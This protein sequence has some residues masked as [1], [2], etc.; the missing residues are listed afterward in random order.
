[1]L[2]FNYPATFNFTQLNFNDGFRVISNGGSLSAIN[3]GDINGDGY[4]DF[5]IS[6]CIILGSK[7]LY[8]SKGII[9]SGVANVNVP[10]VCFNGGAW[11]DITGDF[12][13]DGIDD[14]I[15]QTNYSPIILYGSTEGLPASFNSTWINGKN[16]IIINTPLLTS[17]GQLNGIGDINGDK[18]ADI[19]MSLQSDSNGNAY[20]VILGSKNFPAG[21]S[22]SDL[23]GSNGFQVITKQISLSALPVRDINH[24]G[25]GDVLFYYNEGHQGG[26]GIYYNVILL[27]SKLFSSPLNIDNL[28]AGE[29]VVINLN[30]P[31]AFHD[32]DIYYG[33]DDHTF[34]VSSISIS[35]YGDVDGDKITDM[36]FGCA[37]CPSAQH[38]TPAPT[39]RVY[40]IKGNQNGFPEEIT[41]KGLNSTYGYVFEG[42]LVNGGFGSAV[43]NSGDFNGD[44]FDDIA[45]ADLTSVS[46]IFGCAD[47]V[48]K[49][50][51][52]LNGSNGVLLTGEPANINNPQMIDVI[53]FTD[54]NGD[55]Y[56]D[57]LISGTEFSGNVVLFALLGGGY[58]SD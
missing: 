37:W 7:N 29:A 10:A 3:N 16:G 39:G 57:I 51:V 30:D 56:D 27:G 21:F 38:N 36:I 54:V 45:V 43:A 34:P 9:M 22:I 55:G 50:Q 24:D 1:M 47:F 44:G 46:V 8:P 4:Q 23:D 18:L 32:D 40:V 15:F 41:L 49:S 13:G 53:G 48:H 26:G 20:Y 5:V 6:N 2:N 25:F 42:T 33:D 28:P 11:A 19:F 52:V 12:N 58:I 14:A 17:V 35:A 31:N